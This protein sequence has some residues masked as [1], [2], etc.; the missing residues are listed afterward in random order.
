M[1]SSDTTRASSPDRPPVDFA[2]PHR[3]SAEPAPLQET[4]RLQPMAAQSPYAVYEE[5]MAPVQVRPE[6]R[7]G[8]STCIRSKRAAAWEGRSAISAR[9]KIPQDRLR[10]NRIVLSSQAR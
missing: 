9:R 1:R 7:A 10:P 4:P 3:R 2:G 8:P 5:Q 6:A